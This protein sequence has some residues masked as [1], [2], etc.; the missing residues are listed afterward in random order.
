MLVSRYFFIRISSVGLNSEGLFPTPAIHSMR[1]YCG[2]AVVLL[3]TVSAAD[4]S[5]TN[6]PAFVLREAGKLTLE[7]KPFRFAGANMYW[8]GLDENMPS[9]RPLRGKDFDA[10]MLAERSSEPTQAT[11][12]AVT[13]PTDY[14]IDD[15]M[16]TM[17][18]MGTQV[19]RAHTLGVSTGNGKSYEPGLDQFN[20]AAIE[21]IDYAVASAAK[22]GIKLIIPLTDNWPYYHGG[23]WNFVNWEH[24]LNDDDYDVTA[25]K[26]KCAKGKVGGVCCSPETPKSMACPFYTN[27]TVVNAFKTYIKALLTHTNQ[28]LI[29]PIA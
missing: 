4:T 8:L 13:Y 2:L 22:H 7:G 12:Q 15:A 24:D 21:R 14:R 23:K 18:E 25:G 29:A 3:W 10:F 17:N 16:A 27:V 19:V 20:A 26:G 28:V 5:V 11:E 1:A 9:G 6:A